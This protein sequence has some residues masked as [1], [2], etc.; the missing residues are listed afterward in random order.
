MAWA[1][2]TQGI[3]CVSGG[4]GESKATAATAVTAVTVATF[5]PIA[6]W[7][8]WHGGL[9]CR[10]TWTFL[11][12]GI[13]GFEGRAQVTAVI[14]A[15][16]DAQGSLICLESVTYALTFHFELLCTASLSG[17]RLATFAGRGR[18]DASSWPHPRKLLQEAVMQMH[19]SLILH[20]S[21][22]LVFAGHARDGTA[23]SSRRDAGGTASPAFPPRDSLKT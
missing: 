14:A 21:A 4:I 13:G 16:V 17:H 10:E 8:F 20:P 18:P 7:H 1:K 6:S 9:V 2:H 3:F 5:A 12:L 15:I 22:F 23:S 19:R 11:A